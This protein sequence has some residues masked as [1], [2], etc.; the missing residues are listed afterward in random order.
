M[1]SSAIAVNGTMIDFTQASYRLRGSAISSFMP[2]TSSTTMVSMKGWPLRYSSFEIERV[3]GR[4]F[5]V[6]LAVHLERRVDQRESERRL[7]LL[8]RDF[9]LF[10]NLHFARF[11]AIGAHIELALEL[12]QLGEIYRLLDERRRLAHALACPTEVTRAKRRQ[13]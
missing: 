8:D 2:R 13:H 11:N 3:F 4:A 5:E 1:S 7:E 12:L 6:G 10:E 9:L